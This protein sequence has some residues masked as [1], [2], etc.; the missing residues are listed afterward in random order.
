M[1]METVKNVLLP[2]AGVIVT[3]LTKDRILN[4]LNIKKEKQVVD[5]TQLENVQKALDVWQ[6]MLDD[7]VKRH[8]TQT[9]ELESII[10]KVKKDLKELQELSDKKDE[11][12]YEQR[13]L[14]EKQ[15][16]S[17]KYYKDKYEK[18]KT[19]ES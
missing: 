17:I 6:D 12:I 10:D 16:R 2:T 7:A 8:K 19:H 15:S 1:D 11:I 18:N 3:W 13:E 5:N 14:I 4:A 9:A